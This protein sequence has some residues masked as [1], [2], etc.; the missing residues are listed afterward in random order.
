MELERRGEVGLGDT[1]SHTLTGMAAPR[2]PGYFLPQAQDYLTICSIQLVDDASAKKNSVLKIYCPK[3]LFL[4]R[5]TPVS[6]I[7]TGWMVFKHDSL[8]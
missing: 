5:L 4:H 6:S 3:A 1:L 7:T 8:P 2:H